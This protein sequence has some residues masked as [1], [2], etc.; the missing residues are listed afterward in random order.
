M[1]SFLYKG[2]S[3]PLASAPTRPYNPPTQVRVGV[4]CITRPSRVF[5]Y[6][7][8]GCS[9]AAPATPELDVYIDRTILL[10]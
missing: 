10:L 8:C 7:Y 9:D 6:P 4:L 5:R 1:Q 3:L 2:E